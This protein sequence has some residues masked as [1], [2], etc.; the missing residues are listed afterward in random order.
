MA[1]VLLATCAELPAGDGDEAPVIAALDRRGITAEWAVW[2]D[3]D[4]DWGDALVV[5][6]SVWDY[7]GDRG[8]FLRWLRRLPRVQNPADVIEWNTDKIYLRDLAAARVPIVATSFAAPGKQVPFPAAGEFVVKPSVGAGSFGAGRFDATAGDAAREHAAHL[9]EAGRTVLVQPY[10]REVE[11]A[12]ETA[13]VYFDGAFSHAVGKG[14]MLGATAHRVDRE[15]LFVE[16][17]ITARRPGRDELE[18][19]R[20]ALEVVHDR[21]GAHQLYTRV[22]LLPSSDGPVIVELE[23]TEPSLFLTYAPGDAAETFAAAIVARL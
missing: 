18:I 15:G 2:S 1:D 22:D 12:G 23:L 20:A 8:R 21:F 9:H 4:V 13:L 7:P 6:R 10:L 14:P 19:G 11:T 5:V 3:A 17:K 16:E